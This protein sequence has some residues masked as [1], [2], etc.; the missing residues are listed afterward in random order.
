MIKKT[1]VQFILYVHKWGK[2]LQIFFLKFPLFFLGMRKSIRVKFKIIFPTQFSAECPCAQDK[3]AGILKK[4]FFHSL[5]YPIL[6]I[7]TL[8]IYKKK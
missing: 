5:I 8:S 6:C 2:D 4:K 3:R 1:A 7:L